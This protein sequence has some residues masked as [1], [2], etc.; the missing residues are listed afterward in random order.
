MR[1][2]AAVVQAV[3]VAATDPPVEI[4][5]TEEAGVA[6]KVRLS[7]VVPNPRPNPRPEPHRPRSA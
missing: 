4:G 3:R 7:Q 2:V 5:Q 6:L 1:P